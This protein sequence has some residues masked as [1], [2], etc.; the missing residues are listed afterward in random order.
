M[1]RK[2]V[3]HVC[4]LMHVKRTQAVSGKA[5]ECPA[6]HVNPYKVLHKYA[7]KSNK[8]QEPVLECLYSLKHLKSNLSIDLCAI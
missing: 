2:A 7:L 6:A 4:C 3:G 5:A 8:N 1:G